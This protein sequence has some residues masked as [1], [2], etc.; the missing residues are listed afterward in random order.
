MVNADTTINEEDD[1]FIQNTVEETAD[2]N[3]ENTA[4]PNLSDDPYLQ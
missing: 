4:T 3:D 1:L 2:E